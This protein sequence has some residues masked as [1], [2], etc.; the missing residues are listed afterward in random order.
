MVSLKTP[1]K[2]TRVIVNLSLIIL[3]TVGGHLSGSTQ[4]LPQPSQTVSESDNNLTVLE[5]AYILGIGDFISVKIFDAEDF[6]GEAQVIADGTL[7]LPYIKRLYV[8]GSTL[9]QVTR[10]IE[11]EYARILKHPLIT[12]TL[13]K[14]RPIKIAVSG[15]VSRPGFY[16]LT[17][18]DPESRQP[19]LRYPTLAEAIQKAGGVTLSADIRQIQL[20]R[21][22]PSGGEQIIAI[23][24]WEFLQNGDTRSNITLRDGDTIIIPATT[25][26]N[27]AEVR[28]VA[29]SNLAISADVAHNIIVVGQVNR[30][31][32]YVLIGGDANTERPG[33]YAT[34]TWAIRQAGGITEQADIRQI[35]LYRITQAGTQQ[36]IPVNLWELLQTGD[37]NKDPFLQDGDTIVIPQA[38][39]VDLTEIT[40]I[41]RASF[42]PATIRVS[43]V[44]EIRNPGVGT[45][46]VAPDTTLN[47]A[48]L[49]AGGFN[50][51]SSRQFV[52]LIRLNPDG[53][54][55]QRT[56]AIDF[57]ASPNEQNNPLLRNNDIIVV[58]RSGLAKFSDRTSLLLTPTGSFINQ[59]LSIFRLL[60]VIE[61]FQD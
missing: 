8:Q 19:E 11:T 14:P 49:K 21:P 17:L 31:G 24:F 36:I 47:Q 16:I 33:G 27:Q 58:E 35:Q 28:Q 15:E 4:S 54:I 12:V 48:L 23:N 45:I 60:E 43:V 34:V 6:S 56:I 32:N 29:N 41:A 26:F 9:E 40:P 7:Q 22:Q 1:Y 46:D 53:T 44:G 39:T 50:P 30:P 57:S 61:G 25:H 3:T 2:M 10:M 52:D 20:R 18:F 59:A 42:S 5:P 37:L 51:R 13:T 55:S 38:T